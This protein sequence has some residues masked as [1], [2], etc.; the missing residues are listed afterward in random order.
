MI[1]GTT[2]IAAVLGWP[3]EHSCSPQLHN[4][5]FA[6]TGLDAV[7][8]PLAVHPDHFAATVATLAA[9]GAIGASVTVPHKFAA[10]MVCDELTFD[11]TS[12]GAVNCIQFVGG[13][14]IGHNTDAAGFCDGLVAAGFD[15]A[16][17]RRAVV[18]GSGGA[19]RAVVHALRAHDVELIARTPPEWSAPIRSQVWS[20][21]ALSRAF[22]DADLIVDATSAALDREREATMVNELPVKAIAANAWVASLIY[23]RRPL[24]LERAAA[25][26]RRCLDGSGMLVHQAARAF[27]LWTGRTAP[28]NIMED[29]L[30][31]AVRWKDEV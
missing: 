20:E 19:A 2:R 9:L 15:L 22:S 29:A 13:R 30:F 24:L 11:A 10:A 26:G 17:R 27:L 12:I 7:M 25:A 23:H 28:R 3:I 8:I 14:A 16:T 4:A 18:L 21:S 5:A 6:A 31:L 1:T